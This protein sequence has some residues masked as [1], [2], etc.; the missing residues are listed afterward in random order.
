MA[1]AMLETK[2]FL[3]VG[4]MCHQTIEKG[5][6]AVSFL[7]LHLRHHCRKSLLHKEAQHD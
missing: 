2:R 6:K 1:K 3:Y 7:R 5:L 4:F